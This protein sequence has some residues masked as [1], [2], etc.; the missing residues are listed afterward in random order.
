MIIWIS[1]CL[2]RLSWRSY[3]SPSLFSPSPPS[4]AATTLYPKFDST[5]LQ[6]VLLNTAESEEIVFGFLAAVAPDTSPLM[7]N[8]G[9]VTERWQPHGL[10][11]TYLVDPHGKLQYLALGGCPWEG[12]QI[13]ST[14]KL[15][16]YKCVRNLNFKKNLDLEK[17]PVYGVGA[18]VAFP[19]DFKSGAIAEEQKDS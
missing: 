5:K 13:R 6:I 11:A 15:F 8:D 12:M 7:D 4:Q 3:Y 17:G 18:R 16:L 19:A 14:I 1:P 2:N 9:L 10:P